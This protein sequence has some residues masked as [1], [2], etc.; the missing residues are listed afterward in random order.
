MK[1]IAI[2]DSGLYIDDY[3][4]NE[5]LKGYSVRVENNKIIKEDDFTDEIGH[6]TALYYLISKNKNIDITNIKIFYNDFTI[7][8]KSLELILDYIY[9]SDYFDIINMSFGIVR[10]R[11]TE[12]LYRICQK[13]KDKGTI[14]VSAFDNHGAISFPAALD[15]VIS[16]DTYETNNKEIILIENS[17]VNFLIPNKTYI[18]PW[19]DKKV[20]VKGSSFATTDL[21]KIIV[22][23]NLS[24]NNLN[25]I[26]TSRYTNSLYKEHKI[27]FQITNAVCFPFN[28]EIHAI[29]RFENLLICNIVDYFDLRISGNVGK[30]I[31]Q[32]LNVKSNK[33]VK[34]INE[35]DWDSFD[36]LILGCISELKSITKYDFDK[37]VNKMIDHKKNIYSFEDIYGLSNKNY[38]YPKLLSEMVYNRFGKLFLTDIPVVTVVGTNSKQGKF[39][40]QLLLREKLLKIG[41]KVGQIGTEPSSYLFGIDETFNDGYNSHVR[42]NYKEIL[43][44]TNKMIWDITNKDVEIIISGCQSG[45]LPYNDKNIANYPINHQIFFEALQTDIII[46]VI[47]PFD[48]ISFIRQIYNASIGLSNGK[49]VGF[50]CFP[51]DYDYKYATIKGVKRRIGLEKENKLKKLIAE[52]F[53]VTLYML[54]N[55]NEIDDLI[56]D[57]INLLCKKN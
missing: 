25:E 7:D 57:I 50:V 39:T 43:S 44:I 2:I 19:L 10:Y 40:L 28:K 13:F 20:I 18:V 36:T 48:E 14:L 55:N 16:V 4:K 41:Y 26:S 6:G 51:I 15:N 54:D 37:L 11:S 27:K 35:I 38:F 9:S 56:N 47:N 22:D 5:S 33:I 30:P 12:N 45:F 21:I 46:I 32:L 29:A 52:E 8:S 34:D 1:K 42:L 17:I 49:V 3:L 23:K 31:R 53:N 24:L